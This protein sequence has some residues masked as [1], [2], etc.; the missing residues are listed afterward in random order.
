[1]QIIRIR[2]PLAIRH[3]DGDQACERL[4]VARFVQ[5]GE[6]GPDGD[7][8]GWDWVPGYR[9]RA[10]Q[11][12]FHG[13]YI[14]IVPARRAAL[15]RFGIA[16]RRR[17]TSRLAI[18][19]GVPRRSRV[20]IRQRLAVASVHRPITAET[21]RNGP[22]PRI[23]TSAWWASSRILPM[24]RSRRALGSV[25]VY[26]YRSNHVAYFLCFQRQDS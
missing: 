19:A 20:A 22:G 6:L 16:S 26:G 4:L 25:V 5:S 3:L 1:M 14:V 10:G 12:R 18:A 21:R 13:L 15:H 23:R 11:R 2:L 8:R 7:R 17:N 24:S 9:T